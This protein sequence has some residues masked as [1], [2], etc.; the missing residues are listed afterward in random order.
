LCIEIVQSIKKSKVG[1]RTTPRIALKNAQGQTICTPPTG[2][3]IIRKKLAHME[4]FINSKSEF[5]TFQTA[6]AALPIL[7]RAGLKTLGRNNQHC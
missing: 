3:S 2:E 6:L 4:T 1:I 5:A 7:G